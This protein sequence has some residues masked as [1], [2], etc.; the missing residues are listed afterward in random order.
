MGRVIETVSF[1]IPSTIID[2]TMPY[3]VLVKVKQLIHKVGTYTSSLT[4]E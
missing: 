4:A 2:S 1:P 3:E